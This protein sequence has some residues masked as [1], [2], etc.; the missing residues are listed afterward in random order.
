VVGGHHRAEA[1]PLGQLAVAQQLGR[2][3]LLQRG[4]ISDQCHRNLLRK[5]RE[6]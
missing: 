3:K 5:R 6:T 2:V 1:L 4:G